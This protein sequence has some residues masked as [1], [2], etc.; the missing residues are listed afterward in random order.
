M[1]QETY[2]RISHYQKEYSRVKSDLQRKCAS[3]LFWERAGL[4][5]E[6]HL[7]SKLLYMSQL[8]HLI[9]GLKEGGENG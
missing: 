8:Q 6:E 7:I 2:E 3:G 1:E 9:E 5:A 4:G